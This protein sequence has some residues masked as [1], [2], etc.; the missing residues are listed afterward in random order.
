MKH[1][2]RVKR[3]TNIEKLKKLAGEYKYPE[4]RDE[5]DY[6]LTDSF[7]GAKWSQVTLHLQNGH[8]HSCHH[9]GTHKTPLRE[10]KNNPSALHNTEYKKRL[11]GQMM[12]GIKPTECEYC[13][14]AERSGQLSDRVYKTASPWNL[15]DMDK[16]IS[17]DTTEDIDPSYL[18]VSFGNTCNFKCAYCAPHISS[19]WMEEVQQ[20]GGYPLSEGKEFNSRESMLA[21]GTTPIPNREENPYVDAFW[22]WFPDMSQNLWSMRVTGGEPLLNKNTDKLLDYYIEN[23]HPDTD[24]SINTNMN[25]PDKLID[26]FIEKLKR[27]Q[28]N[29]RWVEVHTSAEGTKAASEYC[30]FGMN[31][32]EWTANMYLMMKEL[33]NIRINV[34]ST[35]NVFSMPSYSDFIAD[36][37][38]MKKH[39]NEF[40]IDIP[41]LRNPEFLTM[42]I[43][44]GYD[45]PR[46][47]AADIMLAAARA[48]FDPN[49][50]EK[51]KRIY[52]MYCADT[53]YTEED[54]EK[55]RR[56]FCLYV[57]QYDQR[58]GTD[59]KKTFPE[60]VEYYDEWQGKDI[61]Y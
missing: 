32:D 2:K 38:Q 57:N 42:F 56:N 46:Q 52:H 27:V 55:H 17:Q 6:T 18:E 29:V 60:L 19:K 40:H 5:L 22:K 34:M 11:R 47:W 51:V 61:F 25:V 15:K 44:Q 45:Q 59:F 37:G 49:E 12:N 4:F 20:F 35:Y 7:C 21:N 3:N 9:P 48:R 58:R 16:I 43:L 13:W 10:L 50:I 36:I 26:S 8:N 28:E 24:L 53:T 31:Y 30:R 41:Y 1:P 23:P 14:R 39:H 33:P 54:L